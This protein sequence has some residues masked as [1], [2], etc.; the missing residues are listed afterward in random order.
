[1]TRSLR[2]RGGSRE[3][4]AIIL[5]ARENVPKFP[6]C[7]ARRGIPLFQS[8][9]MPSLT[10]IN[11]RADAMTLPPWRLGKSVFRHRS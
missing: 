7:N 3:R 9:L 4:N 10:F 5:R 2:R 1:M 6:C 11:R 8:Q